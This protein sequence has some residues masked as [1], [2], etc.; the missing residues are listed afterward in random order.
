MNSVWGLLILFFSSLSSQNSIQ[1]RELY[2]SRLGVDDGLS[3]GGINSIAE[4][5]K[6]YLWIGT[7]DGLNRYDGYRI[8]KYVSQPSNINSLTSS[9]INKIFVDSR[10]WIWVATRLNGLHVYNEKTDGFLRISNN[11]TLIDLFEDQ[12]GDIWCLTDQGYNLS[13]IHI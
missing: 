5:D 12:N 7:P 6:G 4:D 11:K 10:G 9:Y 2:M 3:A 8:K 13:L 1:E